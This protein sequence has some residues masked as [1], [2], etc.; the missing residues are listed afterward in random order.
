MILRY[1]IDCM[2]LTKISLP[3]GYMISRYL[4][5]CMGLTPED[6]INEVDLARGHTIERISLIEDLLSRTKNTT[7]KRKK[8]YR[9]TIASSA[10][11]GGPVKRYSAV[12]GRESVILA[13]GGG[14]GGGGKPP[15]GWIDYTP[16]GREIGNT[17]IVACK[18]P[19]KREIHKKRSDD[20]TKDSGSP[21][22]ILIRFVHVSIPYLGGYM[23][24]R[25]LIDCMGLTKISLPTG[26]MISRYLIDCMGLTKISL[27]T[28]YMISRYLIDCMGLTPED[29][30]NE[31]DLARGHTIE[32][33]SLIE[34]LLSRTKN[35]TRKRKKLYRSTIAS[36]ATSGGPVKTC[37][38]LMSHYNRGGG[39]GGKPPSGWLDY[40]P[41]GR[42]IGNT[43]IV[44]CK[45]PLKREIHKKRSDDI[46]KDRFTP[47]DCLEAVS[48]MTGGRKYVGLVL[49]L[50]NTPKYYNPHEFER[51]H[52]HFGAIRC[53]G[54]VNPSDDLFE[55]FQNSIYNFYHDYPDP[56]ALI[57]V[58]CTHGVNRTGYMITRFLIQCEGWAPEK[59]ISDPSHSNYRFLIQCEGWAPEKAISA[60]A[61]ARGYPIERE[62]YLAHLRNLDR[63]STDFPYVASTKDKETE[64]ERRA[65][66]QESVINNSKDDSKDDDTIQGGETV[67]PIS[68]QPDFIA[69]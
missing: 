51:S 62:N 7:R 4:I 36:S 50:T 5:D 46:T 26:Y 23:I 19:L 45:T 55:V 12:L 16:L 61:D 39:G 56:N 17:R 34:D 27:P 3:T 54:H 53:P 59:A 66:H 8:L 64:K 68:A 25:Y 58:H 35:T 11:S 29:A 41:L 2:G 48:Y 14:G 63:P 47:D 43:R 65:E 60:V 37:N 32:R 22:Y 57:L 13:P 31:V 69:L 42:E 38:T 1:L 33:I 10:T 20:I 40:T 67:V 15:S 52:V 28:G 24:S 18:T 30:I 21:P 9:S 6:A 44:A 49:N